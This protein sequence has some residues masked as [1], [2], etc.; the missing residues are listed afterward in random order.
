SLST[1]LLW[2]RRLRSSKLLPLLRSPV[3]ARL[4]SRLAP[5]PA[6]VLPGIWLFKLLIPRCKRD[7]V[8]TSQQFPWADRALV[9]SA[10]SCR[11][12]FRAYSRDSGCAIGRRRRSLGGRALPEHFSA[13]REKPLAFLLRRLLVRIFAAQRIRQGHQAELRLAARRVNQE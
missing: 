6:V 8:P 3:L 2:I 7:I 13:E 5:P 10:K 1:S 9:G 12:P 4:P 11:E